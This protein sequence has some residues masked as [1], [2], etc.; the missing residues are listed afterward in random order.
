MTANYHHPARPDWVP[1][2]LYPFADRY[3]E[4]DGNLVHYVDQG[5]G[6]VLLMVHGNPDWSFL[7]RDVILGLH[8]T[9]R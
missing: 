8:D 3:I 7:Y 4:I 5:E 2:E 1:D 9:F 6:P